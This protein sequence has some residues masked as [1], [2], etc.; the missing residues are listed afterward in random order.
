MPEHLDLFPEGVCFAGPLRT[1]KTRSKCTRPVSLTS[2]AANIRRL[3]GPPPL[4]RLTYFEDGDL[5]PATSERTSTPP[6]S[7]SLCFTIDAASENYSPPFS[8]TAPRYDS[9][10]QRPTSP[11][12]RADTPYSEHAWRHHLCS[13]SPLPDRTT[14]HWERGQIG[15]DILN[16][17][18][19]FSERL[20]NLSALL[21]DDS[22]RL[23]SAVEELVRSQPE[24][25]S[26]VAANLAHLANNPRRHAGG[27]TRLRTGYCCSTEDFHRRADC[28][29][30]RPYHLASSPR[31]S[32]TVDHGGFATFAL[33]SPP[34]SPAPGRP[35]PSLARRRPRGRGVLPPLALSAPLAR[36]AAPD[37]AA[38]ERRTSPRSP[39]SP[40]WRAISSPKTWTSATRTGP[41]IYWG[42]TAFMRS[43]QERT[44]NEQARL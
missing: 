13:R 4:E 40:R 11:A 44:A 34:A 38:I 15:S 8:P 23:S 39:L 31:P 6:T 7:V 1:D 30:P 28:C 12:A 2:W 10:P 9:L 22:A 25:P 5:S 36:T 20:Q 29:S 43:P 33:P 27:I 32:H 24:L 16:F 14:L 17:G 26:P 19:N 21:I 42:S 3:V 18:A 35:Q 41:P 37:A